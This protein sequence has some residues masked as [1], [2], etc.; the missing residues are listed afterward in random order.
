MSNTVLRHVIGEI[1]CHCLFRLD[2]SFALHRDLL[3]ELDLLIFSNRALGTP[4]FDRAG[5]TDGIFLVSAGTGTMR[6]ARRLRSKDMLD[7]LPRRAHCGNLVDPWS[8]R[9][10][11]PTKND[12]SGQG[13][14]K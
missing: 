1:D 11:S 2:Q 8:A 5:R 7:L 3:D 13:A 10:L 12:P 9:P 6:F 14:R 4:S